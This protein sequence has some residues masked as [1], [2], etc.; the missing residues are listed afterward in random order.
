M[1]GEALLYLN[2][3]NIFHVGPPPFSRCAPLT[4]LTLS[5]L[6]GGE[7]FPHPLPPTEPLW[8]SLYLTLTNSTEVLPTFFGLFAS[9]FFL[10]YGKLHAYLTKVFAW[11]AV[12]IS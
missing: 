3:L 9:F 6:Q 1:L 2:I 12:K 5:I 4:M 11:D 7:L 10:L 8:L